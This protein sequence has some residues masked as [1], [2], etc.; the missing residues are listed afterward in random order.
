[1]INHDRDDTELGWIS[2]PS[3]EVVEQAFA[4]LRQTS[5]PQVPPPEVIAATVEALRALDITQKTSRFQRKRQ[6]MFRIAGLS[7]A[8][9]VIVAALTATL[10][11]F[12]QNGPVGFAQV[13][14][15]V[16]KSKTVSFV[17]KQK[18]GQKPELETKMYIEGEQF[19]YEIPDIL[20]LIVDANRRQGIELY[21]GVKVAKR[22]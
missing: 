22:M 17:I 9:A 2:D 21:S 7:S 3:D 5:V 11:V 8:A 18:L 6:I 10:W 19:R 15:R 13:V 16:Q 1:M 20:T 4:A 12:H 14:E